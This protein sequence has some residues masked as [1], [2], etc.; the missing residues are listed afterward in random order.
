MIQ[1]ARI[2]LVSALLL[3]ALFSLPTWLPVIQVAGGGPAKEQ[4]GAAG[5]NVGARQHYR[6]APSQTQTPAP[7]PSGPSL[8]DFELPAMTL[9]DVGWVSGGG[10]T[11]KVLHPPAILRWD[12]ALA[13]VDWRLEMDS[14]SGAYVD[15]EGLIYVL[16][17]HRLTILDG[18]SG[19]VI[20]RQQVENV[21]ASGAIAAQL[22]P[23]GRRGNRLYLRHHVMQNN[24]LVY[25]LQTGDFGAERWSV[26]EAGYPFD[27]AYLPGEDAFVTFCLDFSAGMEGILTRLSIQDGTSASV[28]IPALGEEEYMAGNGF[29]LGRDHLAYVVD[30]DA[31]A[32]VEI[33]LEAMQVIRQAEYRQEGK[34]S[35]WLPRSVS[36][37]LDLAASPARA[38]RWM[39]QPAVSPGG[40]YLVV[41]GGFGIG[42][43]QT[44]SAWLVDLGSLTPVVEIELPRS[45]EAFH[46]ASDRVLY[47]LLQTELPGAAQ[48]LAF[49]LDSR[50]S[51][52]LDLPTSGRVRQI[53]P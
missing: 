42:G 14:M 28:E 16:E 9:V 3:L 2:I 18:Q 8:G 32:L 47:I 51:I 19:E 30:S 45:P 40:Q 39:S 24:L 43:G 33:D 29:A 53:L 10:T 25:D 36:W 4:N 5:E 13:A 35:G 49:D 22:S 41:D 15:A 26:C 38:K 12:P 17:E 6:R 52:I 46:F 11:Q 37:L 31:G 23:V 50:Q 34:Q 7:T 27:S 48:A 20:S 44:T 1:L 21:P